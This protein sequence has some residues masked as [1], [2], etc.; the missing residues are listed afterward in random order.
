VKP[1]HRC[2]RA[3]RVRTIADENPHR[4]ATNRRRT[5]RN[6][7]RILPENLAQKPVCPPRIRAALALLVLEIIQLREHLHRD[8][9]MVV[10]KAIQAMRVVQE[11]IRVEDEILRE[12]L[13]LGIGFFVEFR[14]EN[15]LF[16][17][18]LEDGGSEHQMAVEGWEKKAAE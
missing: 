3:L 13:G 6:G 2:R 12:S 1:L 14:K 11:D 16:L 8:E 18:G 4:P 5:L 17:V 9:N 15:S 10:L 7:I